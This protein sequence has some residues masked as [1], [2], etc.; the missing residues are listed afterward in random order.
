[1]TFD[2]LE[3]D[4]VGDGIGIAKNS[5]YIQVRYMEQF[6]KEVNRI[7]KWFLRY[8]A[9]IRREE[10]LNIFLAVQSFFLYIHNNNSC[11]HEQQFYQSI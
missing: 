2:E 5:S 10:E 9:E 3:E 4:F 8:E 7:Y 6:I 1:M 11:T